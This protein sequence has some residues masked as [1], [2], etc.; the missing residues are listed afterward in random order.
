[1]LTDDRRGLMNFQIQNFQL[2]N[3]S[4][5]DRSLRGQLIFFP[6]AELFPPGPV[7]YCLLLQLGINTLFS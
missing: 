6:E 5:K 4:L 2:Y 7:I 3:K 1:M